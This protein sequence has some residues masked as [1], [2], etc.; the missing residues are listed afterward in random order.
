MEQN[1][2]M[3]TKELARY[4]QLNEKTILKMAQ[5]GDLP[6]IKI[7]NQW[8]FQLSSIDNQLQDQLMHSSNNELDELIKTAHHIIPLS[9]LIEPGL[10]VLNL[11][12]VHT[13][14]VLRE[15]AEHAG[16]QG[17]TPR[18]DALFVQLREREKM[19]STAIGS[20][21]AIPHPRNPGTNLFVKPNIMFCRSEKGV[22][23]D[24]PDKKPVRLFFMACAPNIEVHLRLIAKISKLLKTPGIIAQLMDVRNKEEVTTIL[25]K[26]ERMVIPS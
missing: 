19:L 18:T 9:R 17:I 2:I 12:A 22:E 1:K 21:V 26:Q 6:G 20:G 25:L 4:I 15:I 23:F 24:A 3:T 7:G 16:D 13:I 11:H 14:D 10:M 5:N 8:R